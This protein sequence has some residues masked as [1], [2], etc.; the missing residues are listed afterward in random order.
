MSDF[1]TR[2]LRDDEIRAAHELF[3]DGM[4][5]PRYS[6]AEWPRVEPGF[7]P[8]GQLGVFD[9]E[10]IGTARFFDAEMTVPGGATVPMAGVT[11]VAVRPDRTRR[12]VLRA[13]MAA[14]LEDFASRGVAIAS[15]YPTEGVIYGRFGYGMASRFRRY[16]VE[17]RRAALRPD[18][19]G[20]G[21]ITLLDLE[22]AAGRWP[23]LYAAI[24]LTRPG[25]MTRPA[26]NWAFYENRQRHFSERTKTVVHRGP[27]GVD[28][29]A[30]YRVQGD[31]KERVLGVDEL[32]TATPAALADLWR[33]LLG[34]DLVDRIE[35]D[36]RPVDDGAELLFTDPRMLNVE[37]IGD[38][39]WMRL[40]DVPAALAAR[41]Y[42][43]GEPVV[44]EVD[45]PLVP[46][47]SGAYRITPDGAERT[48]APAALRLGVETL[49]MA[50]LGAWRPST[51]AAAGRITVLDS[52][53]L[54]AADTLFAGSA[55]PWC[56]TYF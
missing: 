21:E 18:A 25:S 33:F 53:A 49:V 36:S 41:A 38:E 32:R 54:D 26:R 17:R 45:D 6:D 29:Y 16:A 56:G 40:V 3:R 12:G 1:R 39:A 42:G 35:V 20:G 23:E 13:L 9:P 34:V 5:V 19:P 24:P 27:G 55:A 46:A 44:L 10:L 4:H 22:D 31:Y 7:Q 50:Y 8:G 15:L 51:L 2:T 37:R 52:A 47:N 48:D 14:Q 30:I 43:P 11:M 28:G